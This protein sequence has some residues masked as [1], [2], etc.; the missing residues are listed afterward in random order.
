MHGCL[1]TVCVVACQH[2]RYLVAQQISKG[3]LATWHPGLLE[4]G[5]NIAIG[6]DG[7]IPAGGMTNFIF[8]HLLLLG[9]QNSPFAAKAFRHVILNTVKNPE[10]ISKRPD[11]G[12]ILFGF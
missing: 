10:F 5:K 4:T 2:I 12:Q 7:K 1:D 11:I 8:L 9:R 6:Q 3:L